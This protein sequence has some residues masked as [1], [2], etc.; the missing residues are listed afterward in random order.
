MKGDGRQNAHSPSLPVLTTVPAQHKLLRATRQLPIPFPCP[1]GSPHGVKPEAVHWVIFTGS[2]KPVAQR[3]NST[4]LYHRYSQRTLQSRLAEGQTKPAAKAKTG[5][6]AA[7]TYIYNETVVLLHSSSQFSKC[8]PNHRL[9]W[10]MQVTLPVAGQ[11]SCIPHKTEARDDRMWWYTSRQT[12]FNSFIICTVYAMNIWTLEFP[13]A[14]RVYN[15]N[16]ATLGT[17]ICFAYT[18]SQ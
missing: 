12:K 15:F 8:E 16:T 5:S 4:A 17:I 2:F 6:E 10:T 14:T 18:C 1:R 9:K 13:T 7:L 3:G 11:I